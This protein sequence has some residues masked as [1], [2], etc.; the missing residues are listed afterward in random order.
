MAA[1][2][3]ASSSL[4]VAFASVGEVIMTTLLGLLNID[5]VN[6]RQVLETIGDVALGLG[7]EAIGRFCD[8]AVVPFM[9]SSLCFFAASCEHS[10]PCISSVNVAIIGVA[11]TICLD[12]TAVF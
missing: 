4:S 2:A 12:M 5:T 7:N 6:K 11:F 1:L 8:T 9:Q 10:C 3:A